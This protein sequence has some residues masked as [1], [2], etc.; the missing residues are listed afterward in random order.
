MEWKELNI[1][2]GDFSAM[3]DTRFGR[4][5]RGII[6][7]VVP[8]EISVGNIW[9]KEGEIQQ[10][11]K[12]TRYPTKQERDCAWEKFNSLRNDLSRLIEEE[13]ESK[14]KGSEKLKW[15]IFEKIKS[16]E[17]TT[18]LGWN[19][20]DITEMKSLGSILQTASS[21]LSEYKQ[22]MLG[23]HKQEC[24]E[25][26]KKMRELHNVWWEELK[27]GKEKK[28][29]YSVDKIRRNIE[30][31]QDRHKKATE[32]LEYFKSKA[33]DLRD[34]I[35]SAWNDGWVQTAE[36]R[37]SVIEDKIEDIEKY[38]EKIEEWIKEDENKL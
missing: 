10:G 20:V 13:R 24:F 35:S 9:K 36:E 18:Q 2:I 29:E 23:E 22:E 21:M 37:L 6:A 8:F 28:N 26:I 5:F 33:E 12:E 11:L 14:S 19:T 3:I 34:K 27:K 32:S 31:N 16:A 1:L 17:P 4:G 30:T 7:T 25:A 38:L 15:N